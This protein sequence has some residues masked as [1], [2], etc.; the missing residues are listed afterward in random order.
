[1][2]IHNLQAVEKHASRNFRRRG[3]PEWAYQIVREVAY[4]HRV[5][6]TDVASSNRCRDVV[7]ARTEAMYRIKAA[8]ESVS[9][10]QIGKWFEKDHTSILHGIASYQERTG[11]APLFHYNLN[12]A[13]KR[14]AA[15]S[16]LLRQKVAGR[17]ALETKE[18]RG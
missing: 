16:S 7:A 13:R 8:K 12:R 11:A 15:I 2:N 1:M 9:S 5:Y 3:M 14:N 4:R 6:L 17:T 18:G 10:T